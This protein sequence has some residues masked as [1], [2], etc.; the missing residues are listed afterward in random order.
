M[1]DVP[2]RTSA[3]YRN[4]SSRFSR[5]TDD[6]NNQFYKIYNIRLD[7]MNKYILEAIKTKWGDKYRICKLYKLAEENDDICVVIGTL[8]KDQK[9][10]PSV[11]KQLAESNQLMPQPILAHCTDESDVLYIEDELQRFQLEGNRNDLILPVS[12]IEMLYKI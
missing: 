8:F 3:Y 1:C 12:T 7:Q 5:K 4:L 6:Y 10:K 11:L 2:T 9:L